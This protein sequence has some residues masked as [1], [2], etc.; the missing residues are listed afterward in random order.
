[1]R[2]GIVPEGGRV[3]KE[4]Q[5][6]ADDV[7]SENH[8]VEHPEV[9]QMTNNLLEF[10]WNFNIDVLIEARLK[11]TLFR[12]RWPIVPTDASLIV[13]QLLFTSLQFLGFS[14]QLLLPSL[15]YKCKHSV[16]YTVACGWK[17]A[18]IPE[19]QRWIFA[20]LCRMRNCLYSDC[21]LVSL[22][23]LVAVDWPVLFGNSVC[24]HP[25]MDCNLLRRLFSV[26]F[27]PLAEQL[28]PGKRERTITLIFIPSTSGRT[29]A[30]QPFT[31]VINSIGASKQNKQSALNDWDAKRHLRQMD[32]R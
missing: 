4:Q 7:A 8:G 21:K 24:L 18:I 19:V 15:Q 14:F 28:D 23:G 32:Y 2:K 20:V 3:E 13:A 30:P 16:K 12:Q 29:N 31:H 26:L 27:E 9:V 6:S 1:M 11:T 5:H 25:Q 10:H 22:V 17:G